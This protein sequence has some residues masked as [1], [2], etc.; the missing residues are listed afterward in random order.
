MYSPESESDLIVKYTPKK[1]GRKKLNK[2]DNVKPIFIFYGIFIQY[3][4]ER[5]LKIK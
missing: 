2:T 4:L 1:F 3:I 5:H